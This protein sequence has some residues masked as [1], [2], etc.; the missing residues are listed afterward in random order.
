[1]KLLKLSTVIV[2]AG[3][4]VGCATNSD[5]ENLQGQINTLK[6][7]VS[8]AKSAANAA[9]NAASDAASRAA[10]AE[11]AANRAAR[12]AEEVNSKLDR[13]FKRSMMK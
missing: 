4:A 6:T 5:I 13:M 11:A 8:S 3:L 9:N 7:D 1:M 10:A 12:S 2:A